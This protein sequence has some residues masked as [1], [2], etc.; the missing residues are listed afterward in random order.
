MTWGLIELHNF[1]HFVNQLSQL[2][3]A[4]VN[5]NRRFWFRGQSSSIPHDKKPEFLLRLKEMNI[6]GATLFPG[7]D[8]L[9]QSV[10]ELISLGQHYSL[11]RSTASA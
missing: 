6:T 2:V 3:P 11:A 5:D 1:E 9:G 4:S 7:V 10:K 8:G